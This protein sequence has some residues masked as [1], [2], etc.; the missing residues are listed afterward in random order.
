MQVN[1]EDIESM[2]ETVTVADVM[3]KVRVEGKISPYYKGSL[4]GY[5]RTDCTPLLMKAK[6]KQMNKKSGWCSTALRS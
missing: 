3:L 4:K 2:M 6:E 5:I 1:P